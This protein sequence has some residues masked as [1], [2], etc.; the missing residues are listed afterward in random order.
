MVRTLLAITLMLNTLAAFADNTHQGVF[1]NRFRT[2]E[3]YS[4]ADRYAPPVISLYDPASRII[5]EFDELDLDR[6]YLRCRLVHCDAQWRPEGLVDS[7][8]LDGFNEFVIDDYAFSQATVAHYVHYT[9]VIP[10][11][12]MRI[13]QPGNYLLQVYD[14][15][16]PD[17]TLLQARFGVVAP[18]AK[19]GVSVSSRTDIDSNSSHQQLE[20]AVDT[21]DM[22]LRDPFTELKIVVTQNGRSDNEVILTTP[23][24]LNG[25]VALYEHLRPLIFEGGNEYRRFET[26]SLY[27]PGMGVEWI[28][29][30]A[31][32]ANMGLHT[33]TPR[34][35]YLYD[36]TQQGR[37]LIRTTDMADPSTEADY[38]MTHFSLE[39][40]QLPG[41]DIFIDGD[42][43]QRRFDPSSR[44]VYNHA[45]G[46]YELSMLLKQGA[47]NYQYLFV[48]SGTMRGSTAPVEGDSY[49]T[50]NEYTVRV[51]HR[52]SGSR[53]DRLVGV[54]TVKSGI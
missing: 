46:R 23:T 3:V 53:F 30:E 43:V 52:P 34:R 38:V 20:I 51:Y 7:E 54:G 13:T 29:R 33:D 10:S 26:V 2:L 1:D 28:D 40:P 5:V 25:K 17:T 12:D 22:Q 8:F 4:E 48:P 44:M 49:Q 18:E 15:S 32:V 47:Y 39:M 45:T 6:R 31:P 21:R 9:I 14:E 11:E 37:F 27:Y 16:D 24:R 36:S 19:V 41:G 42:L 50:V 35:Q